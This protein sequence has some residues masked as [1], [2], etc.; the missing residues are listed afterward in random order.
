MKTK[1]EIIQA[2]KEQHERDLESL[3]EF[4]ERELPDDKPKNDEK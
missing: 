1:K 3:I 2:I 4:L